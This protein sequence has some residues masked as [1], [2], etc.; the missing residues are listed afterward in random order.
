MFLKW[1]ILY[2][3]VSIETI[4]DATVKLH[5][6]QLWKP[7]IYFNLEPPTDSESKFQ[8][9]MVIPSIIVGHF[10][11]LSEAPSGAHLKKS[12][13][14]MFIRSRAAQAAL[15]FHT[16]LSPSATH[17]RVFLMLSWFT[18]TELILDS[19]IVAGHVF[20][21]KVCFPRVSYVFIDA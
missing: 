7:R 21:F 2:I 17:L 11:L 10:S 4:Y 1:P 18:G 19:N 6:M 13:G 5:N 3:M 8:H 16:A 15:I 12:Q 20:F 9:K 14:S